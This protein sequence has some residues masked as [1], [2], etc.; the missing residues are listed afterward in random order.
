MLFLKKEWGLIM[1]LILQII[2]TVGFPIACC[3][4][5][6]YYIKTQNNEY[7]EDVKALT[8]KYERAIDKFSKSIDKNTQILTALDAKLGSKE[9]TL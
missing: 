7:R 4:F 5:L 1:D 6:G 2:Q 8:D 9:E 3:I